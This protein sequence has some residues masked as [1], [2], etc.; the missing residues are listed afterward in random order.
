MLGSRIGNGRLEKKCWESMNNNLVVN[1]YRKNRF[2]YTVVLL[3]TM[4][5]CASS[6]SRYVLLEQRYVPLSADFEIK[7]YKDSLPEK[8]FKRVSRLDVHL[9]KSH[10]VSSDLDNAL[11]LLKKEARMSGAHAIIDIKERRSAVLETKIYHV[12]ATGIR[13]LEE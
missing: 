4:I 7:V 13:F 2:I 11:P 6:Q 12:T 8:K 10:F 9:E 3:L 1:I 5:S